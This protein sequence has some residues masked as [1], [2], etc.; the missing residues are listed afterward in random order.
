MGASDGG[1]GGER[2]IPLDSIVCGCA[3]EVLATFPGACIDLTVTSPPYDN[4]RTYNGYTF[5]FE[6]MARQLYR[7]TKPGGVVVWVVGDETRDGS[8]SGT[9]FRQALGFMEIGF[10]L[11]DTMIYRVPGTGA[12]GTNDA[13]WQEFE[14]MFIL[15]KG[16]IKTSN[17]LADKPAK[18]PGSIR[19]QS[20]RSTNGH[21]NFADGV[22][23]K[24]VTTKEFCIRGNVWTYHAGKNADYSERGFAEVG[25][26]PAPF[27]EKLAEDHILSWSN[28]GDLVL[29]P[30]C[31]SGTTLKMAIRHHRHFI[32][33]DISEA[34]CALAQRRI[35]AV[36][37]TL[38]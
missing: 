27:P 20:A 4:L 5:D 34:Y 8:E 1:W 38:L 35:G 15:T 25:G 6:T 10:R 26:H 18:R 17:R 19:E 13:Y 3:E 23:K 24:I 30:M 36:Q 28:A 33:I 14:Y 32:G 11:L 16:R 9:S 37:E 21:P 29:D 22:I 2:V 12:K 31:G 7:I